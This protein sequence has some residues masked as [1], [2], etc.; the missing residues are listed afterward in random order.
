MFKRIPKKNFFKSETKTVDIEKKQADVSNVRDQK[1]GSRNVNGI[2]QH[3]NDGQK[4]TN[5]LA[6]NVNRKVTQPE[7]VPDTCGVKN[8]RE[9]DLKNLKKMF[10]VERKEKK[11]TKV[12]VAIT[13]L[14]IASFF[15]YVIIVIVYITNPDYENNMTSSQLTFYLI[16]FRLYNINNMANPIFYFFFDVKFREEVFSLYR[17][18]WKTEQEKSLK[19]AT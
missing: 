18:F 11:I 7:I 2:N 15:P 6:E 14:F 3:D 5:Q 4:E 19:S 12:L 16:A 10:P 13:L 9:F 17:S 1:L 8:P